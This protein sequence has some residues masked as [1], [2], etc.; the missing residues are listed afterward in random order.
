M[1][2]DYARIGI[3]NRAGEE[4]GMI[5]KQKKR[6]SKKNTKRHSGDNEDPTYSVEQ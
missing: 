4:F 5:R 1:I 2:Y 6:P 3:F